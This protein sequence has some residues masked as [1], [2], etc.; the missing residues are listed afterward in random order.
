MDRRSKQREGLYR[1]C[2]TALVVMFAAAPVFANDTEGK[3]Y[4]DR[5]PYYPDMRNPCTKDPATSGR[6]RC[7]DTNPELC[8]QITC[9]RPEGC[10]TQVVTTRTKPEKNGRS[11]TR[12]RTQA[13]GFGKGLPTTVTYRVATDNLT[14]TRMTPNAASFII[15]NR[16][17]GN[18]ERPSLPLGMTAGSS[19]SAL[20]PQGC[21]SPFVVSTRSTTSFSATGP[22]TRIEPEPDVSCKNK[23]G[24]DR[25]PD[26]D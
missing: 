20:N 7:S 25:H 1:A 2:A 6:T 5:K 24:R 15:R 21:A 10:G 22:V 19:C 3:R 4:D 18:P 8:D 13:S 11:E 16:D 17:M 23:D 14:V 26:D 12:V 9:D